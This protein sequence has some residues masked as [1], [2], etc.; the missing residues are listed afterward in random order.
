MHDLS[1]RE[2]AA[3]PPVGTWGGDEIRFL[4][5]LRVFDATLEFAFRPDVFSPRRATKALFDLVDQIELFNASCRPWPVDA[6]IDPDRRRTQ[7]RLKVA[8]TVRLAVALAPIAPG[9]ARQLGVALLGASPA[10]RWLDR[11][12]LTCPKIA[13]SYSGLELAAAELLRTV[14]LQEPAEVTV[15]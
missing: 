9:F 14:S 6:P 15:Q 12:I 13:P 2:R 5:G 7:I 4:K 10:L 3:L 8:A 1:D 11:N